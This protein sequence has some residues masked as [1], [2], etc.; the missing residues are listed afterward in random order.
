MVRF[1]GTWLV[2]VAVGAV[3]FLL[4]WHCWQPGVGGAVGGRP[5][6]TY[7]ERFFGWPATYQAELWRSD[8]QALSSRILAAA[9]FYYPGDEMSLEYCS[10]GTLA[11][12]VDVAVALLL[13]LA[14][15]VSMEC[16]QRGAWG[17]QAVGLLTT[18]ALL[19]LML[20]AVSRSASVSL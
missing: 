12:V 6:G 4:N 16:V 15:A 2:L 9:P 11:L 1:R 18:S 14:V 5:A 8:E 10:V 19:L 7:L 3:L 13:C 20:W 17:S